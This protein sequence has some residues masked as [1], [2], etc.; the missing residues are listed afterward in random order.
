[1]RTPGPTFSWRLHPG[2][3]AAASVAVVITVLASNLALGGARAETPS[4]PAI[5]TPAAHVVTVDTATVR[6]TQSILHQDSTF[7]PTFTPGPN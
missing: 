6:A 2:W 5:Q 7:T 3:Q 1:M 4:V